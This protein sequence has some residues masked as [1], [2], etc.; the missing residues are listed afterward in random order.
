MTLTPIHYLIIG[1]LTG[2][3]VVSGIMALRGSRNKHD[4]DS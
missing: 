3:V 4:K 2:I 1:V